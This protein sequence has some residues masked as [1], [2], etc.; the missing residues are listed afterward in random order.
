MSLA[1]IK[2][3]Q[4]GDRAMSEGRIVWAVQD[5]GPINARALARRWLVSS[6]EPELNIRMKQNRETRHL[7]VENDV[8]PAE[9]S[10]LF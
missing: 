10:I 7:D 4:V 8:N 1:C 2:R 9:T 6:Q 3:V 5:L